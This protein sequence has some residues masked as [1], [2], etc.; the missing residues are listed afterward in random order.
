MNCLSFRRQLLTDPRRRRAA[1]E[2]HAAQC[3]PCART[4][5]RA[6]DFETSLKV[7]LMLDY[8]GQDHAQPKRE[9]D[10]S[11]GADSPKPAYDVNGR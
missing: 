3:A 6:L 9:F 8:G 10:G 5:Q 1:L 2:A 7:V 11:P 4:L